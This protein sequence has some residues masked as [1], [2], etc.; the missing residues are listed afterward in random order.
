MNIKV[1][2]IDLAK[3]VFQ[4]CVLDSENRVYSNTQVK[5]VKLLERVANFPQGTLIAVEACATSNHW[6]RQF[7]AMGYNVKI[8]PTQHVKQL[9][10]HQKNDANDALAICE[11]AF[12]PNVHPVPVK[13]FAQQDLKAW[14]CARE[15]IKENR[16]ALGNQIR[17]I[18]AEYGVIFDRKSKT[19]I[20]ELPLALESVENEL[21]SDV[22][23]LLSNL[24]DEYIHYH[25]QLDTLT[26][27]IISLAKQAPVYNQLQSLPGFGPIVISHFIAEIGSGEQFSSGRRAAAWVGLVPK[28]R[29]TG[30][31]N[32]TG[33]ITK[34][35][36][37]TLRKQVIHGARAVL[38]HADKHDDVMSR[39][40]KKIAAKKG[41]NIAAV[42][43]ANKLVRIAWKILTSGEKFDVNK[44]CAA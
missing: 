20:N 21:T 5:R 28:V 12:R 15:R 7:L 26:E 25:G 41:N 32:R 34:R 16:V 11:A 38:R 1:V 39:W 2:G 10:Y 27:K 37:R 33:S 24:L 18:A 42:A 44:A 3:S 29:G 13:S 40:V 36:N 6:A 9:T 31:K 4:I 8:I 23:E 22:R 17:A 35:G 19:L 43:L 30:G 14:Q